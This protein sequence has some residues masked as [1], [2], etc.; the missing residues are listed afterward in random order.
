MCSRYDSLLLKTMHCITRGD[1]EKLNT[2]GNPWNF[3]SLLK[4]LAK[5]NE[6][7]HVHLSAPTMKCLA[8]ITPNYE[9]KYG[10]NGTLL[11]KF[12]LSHRSQWRDC[13][14]TDNFV[15]TV[16]METRRA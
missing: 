6:T 4:L 9:C 12:D 5:Y 14:L 1:A 16:P 2:P 7:L 3:L 11:Y 13:C 8:Q 10:V 15:I